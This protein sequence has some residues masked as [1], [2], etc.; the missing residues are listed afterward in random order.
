MNIFRVLVSTLLLFIPLYP[1]FPLF[2]ALNTYVNFRLDDVLVGLSILIWLVFQV[3]HG[4][5]VFKE[6]ISWLFLLFFASLGL[7]FLSGVFIHQTNFNN[8]YLLHTLRK[9]EYISLFFI[10]IQG[11]RS[12]QDFKYLYLFTC[13]AA[14]LVNIYGI[15]QKFYNFPVV[16][17]MNEEF[18]K[19]I[20]LTISAWTRISSTFAGHYD[21]AIY[22]SVVLVIIGGVMFLIPKKWLILTIPTWL[23]TYY[24][25]TLTASRVSIFALL[26]GFSLCLIFLRKYLWLIPLWVLVIL[27]IRSSDDL[28][29]RLAATFTMVKLPNIAIFQSR[30]STLPTTIPIPTPTIAIVAITPVNGNNKPVIPATPTP[31]ATPVRARPTEGY[32]PVDLDAGV[33]RSGEIRFNVEWPRAINAFLKSPLIGNSPGSMGLATDNEYLRLAGEIGLLGS[34]IFYSILAWF[35]YQTFLSSQKHNRYKYIFFCAML[36]MLVN[37]LFIDAFSASKTAYLFWI[38]MAAYYQCLKLWENSK[39]S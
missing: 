19:G 13:L 9:I 37:S 6:K 25:L 2:D 14:V 3:K 34:L 16:S 1:K 15:G 18:S 8:I 33:A 22:A 29:K 32:P 21:L 24:V 5:P 31:Y 23:T 36:T 35:V 20:L 7:S 39:Q 26:G 28:S 17:T 30:P 4:F 27:S 11:I 38:M 10:T 12:K